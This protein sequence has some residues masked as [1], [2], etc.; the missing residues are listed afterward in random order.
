MTQEHF[1][2]ISIRRQVHRNIPCHIRRTERSE[3]RRAP[4]GQHRRLSRREGSYARN[5][6]ETP[7]SCRLLPSSIGLYPTWISPSEC[8]AS[9]DQ[10]NRPRESYPRLIGRAR[11]VRTLHV[12]AH[13]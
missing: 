10:V 2:R 11:S 6:D 1:L 3:S 13:K 12:A 5:E 8:I 7:D 9:V 4:A